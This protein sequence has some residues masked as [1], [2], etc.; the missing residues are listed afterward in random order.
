MKTLEEVRKELDS[1]DR[2]LVALFEQRMELCREVARVKM[3]MGKAVLDQGREEAVLDSR[4]AMVKDE[5]L[6]G[7]VR[8][9]YQTLMTLSRE[10]QT[11]M[12][13]EAEGHA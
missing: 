1:T 8:T 7:A 9:L 11:R 6:S 10:E 4:A 2:A 5:Q 12:M 13:K 3:A